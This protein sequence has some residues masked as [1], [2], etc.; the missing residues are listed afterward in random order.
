MVKQTPEDYKFAIQK[1]RW[2]LW[3]VSELRNN[4]AYLPQEVQ[5]MH[6][7]MHPRN[8]DVIENT[9][10][11]LVYVA[12]FSNLVSQEN[13]IGVDLIASLAGE[14]GKYFTTAL[15]AVNQILTEPKSPFP[16]DLFQRLK[17]L[18]FYN[19]VHSLC[20]AAIKMARFHQNLI[21]D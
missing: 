12:L 16:K 15:T 5:N 18:V 19:V 21:E 8:L 17:A 9:M 3:A 7:D 6:F 20:Q 10:F 2:G 1:L 13:Q 4:L 14:A 11:G